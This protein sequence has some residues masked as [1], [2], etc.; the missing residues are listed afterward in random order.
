[1]TT[2]TDTCS[3]QGALTKLLAQGGAGPAPRTFNGSSERWPFFSESVELKTGIGGRK[4]ITGSVSLASEGARTGKRIVVGNLIMEASPKALHTWLPR[5][6]WGTVGTAGGASTYALG[7]AQSSNVFDLMFHRE[8]GVFQYTDCR[9]ARLILQSQ[10]AGDVEDPDKELVEMIVQIMGVDE[11][12]DATY[13]GSEPSFPTTAGYT[14]Y[15]HPEGAF[16]FNSVATNYSRFRLTIDNMLSP[17]FYNSLTPN[18]FRSQSR[19]ITLEL[20]SPFLC[21]NLTAGRNALNTGVP[22]SLTFTMGT[23]S[24]LFDFPFVR[25]EYQTP[26]VG[27]KGEIPFDFKLK[28]FSTSGSMNEMSVT[29]DH[30]P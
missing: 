19:E 23:M 20:S 2:C 28:A 3:A 9:V 29:N 5:A 30:T 7:T 21:G 22:A 25:N 17:K 16:G 10:S 18:C 15:I 8:N 14:S 12:H 11:N 26:T 4:R 24:T 27:G 6:M 13:P 1:M